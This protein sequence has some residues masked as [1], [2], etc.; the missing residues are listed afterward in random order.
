MGFSNRKDVINRLIV[1][2][3]PQIPHE[4]DPHHWGSIDIPTYDDPWE[5]IVYANNDHK[6]YI[7]LSI[8][9]RGP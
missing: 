5:G 8:I 7:P 3:T 9:Q 1:S 6:D 4:N 2:F